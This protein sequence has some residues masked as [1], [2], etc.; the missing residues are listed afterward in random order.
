MAYPAQARSASALPQSYQR[1]SDGYLNATRMC[2]AYRRRWYDYIRTNETRAYIDALASETHI[3]ASLL[4]QSKR[5]N[6]KQF[7]QGTW[8]HPKLA[9]HLAQWLNP[10]FAVA[11]S[12]LVFDWLSG[13]TIPKPFAHSGDPLVPLIEPMQH[14]KF[15]ACARIDRQWL[16]KPLTEAGWKAGDKLLAFNE[17]LTCISQQRTYELLSVSRID[18]LYP[19]RVYGSGLMQNQIFDT[20]QPRWLGKI[21]ERL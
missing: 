18:D 1:E 9:I 21:M 15:G 16:V 2:Q 11:V 6:S 19:F 10:H 13:K 3:P 8:V 4:I 7:T 20:R 12:N 5:G 17:A 14:R